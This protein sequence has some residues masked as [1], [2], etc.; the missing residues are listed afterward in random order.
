MPKSKKKS[1]GL[2]DTWGRKNRK[3]ED[4]KCLN[5][6][7]IFR[8][9]RTTSKYCSRKCMWANNG[10]HNK[11]QESWWVNNKGYVEGRIWLDEHTQIR[12]KKHRWNME[13]HLNRKLLSDE[14]VHHKDGNKQNNAI[15]NLEVI[16]HG[17]HTKEHNKKRT[18]KRGYKLKITDDERKRR[19]EAMRKIRQTDL[20]SKAKGEV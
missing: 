11:K 4:I 15:E 8:P 16:N 6:T 9:L 12:V 10:G 14:D 18:W 17:F 1:T 20:I 7:K 3:L 2:L 5:C 13:K 19:S